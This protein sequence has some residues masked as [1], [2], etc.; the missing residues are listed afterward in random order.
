MNII[1]TCGRFHYH[2]YV[3]GL[4]EA[5]HLSAFIFSHR[6]N[7]F[8]N[9]EWAKNIWIKEYLL[10]FAL[11][12]MPERC[13]KHLFPILHDIWDDQ[14]SRI[15]PSGRVLHV[16]LHGT[17]IRLITEAKRQGMVIL[18]EAVNSHPLNY[19]KVIQAE[20]KRLGLPFNEALPQQ[21]S[22]L[23][24]EIA[25]CDY[26]LTPSKFVKDSFLR[27]GFP[28]W[29]LF[30][31]PFGANLRDFC[32]SHLARFKGP[33]NVL[34]V[35]QIIPRKGI[36]FLLEAW[37]SLG[38]SPEQATLK[39]IGRISGELEKLL[40]TMPGVI[41]AGPKSKASVVEELQRADV[42][43]LPTLEEGFSVSILEAMACGCPVIVTRASGAEGVVTDGV[44]G[45]I[46]APGSAVELASALRDMYENPSVRASMGRAALG[47][48]VSEANWGN[49]REKLLD[50]Y[51]EIHCDYKPKGQE[52]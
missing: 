15:L 27:Y 6:R 36:S 40:P 39:I 18:G 17:S 7:S 44:H 41:L 14:A 30:C 16:M 28:H 22:K 26:V 37:Q 46:V 49:Y 32:P 5:G 2:N 19:H 52:L 8:Y 29:R 21:L 33:L 11:R 38:F 25:M 13:H 10:G 9:K 12:A 45:R 50:I 51:Q 1:A 23:V 42:F 34:C 24:K 3:E 48:V 31:L 47:R 43:V 20:R 4:A 35:S